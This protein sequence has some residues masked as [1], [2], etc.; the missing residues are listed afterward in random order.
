MEHKLWINGRWTDSIGGGS[1]PVENP[2]TGEKI[3][4]VVDAS[5]E[6]VNLAVKTA[7]ESFY[8][9]RWSRLTPAERSKAI[10]KFADLLEAQSEEFARVESLNTGK[11]YQ[12]V[13]LGADLMFAIDNLDRKSVV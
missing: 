7:T 5:P 2:A 1:M 3:G 9:G 8:D 13:S 10:W 11:P 6:D 12:F 4:D